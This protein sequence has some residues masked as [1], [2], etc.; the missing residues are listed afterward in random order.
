MEVDDGA[1]ASIQLLINSYPKYIRVNK[2]PLPNIDEKLSIASAL[3][4]KGLLITKD[5]LEYAFE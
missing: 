4:D 5:K 3:Y 1:V 2:L